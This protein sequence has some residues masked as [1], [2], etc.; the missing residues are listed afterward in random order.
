[1][2]TQGADLVRDLDLYFSTSEQQVGFSVLTFKEGSEPGFFLALLSPNADVAPGEVMPKRVTF[3]IDT[4]GSMRGQRMEL[5]KESLKYCVTRLGEKDR[6]NVI[7]F[8]S[9]SESLF[10]ALV[11]A[12]RENVD[13]AAAFVG[14]LEAVGGTAID[15][16]LRLA[17]KDN[18]ESGAADPNTG[19]YMDRAKD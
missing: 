3:V 10:G 17:L 14:R 16:A 2:E 12:S 1:M 8:G 9:D 11:P 19:E 4:S 15:E 13:K 18:A 7:R 6:F 5:A